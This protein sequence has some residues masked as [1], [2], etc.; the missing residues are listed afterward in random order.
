MLAASDNPVVAVDTVSK[1]VT[2]ISPTRKVSATGEPDTDGPSTARAIPVAHFER[3]GHE[4]C[5]RRKLGVLDDPVS[6]HS[7]GNVGSFSGHYGMKLSDFDFSTPNN[8]ALSLK[9]LAEYVRREE[10]RCVVVKQ[11]ND[12]LALGISPPTDLETEEGWAP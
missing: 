9:A 2:Q 7:L 4:I 11:T 6:L 8:A 10:F 1:G 12:R 3:A 5:A